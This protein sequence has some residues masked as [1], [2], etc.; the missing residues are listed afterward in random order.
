MPIKKEI[1]N[2]E[3]NF[4]T[5]L[6][7]FNVLVGQDLCQ[8]HSQVWFMIDFIKISVH[9]M[10]LYNYETAAANLMKKSVMKT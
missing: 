2:K 5:I 7:R 9:T 6:H 3:R 4:S 10:K 8:V 1:K